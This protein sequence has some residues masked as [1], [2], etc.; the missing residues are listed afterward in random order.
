MLDGSSTASPTFAPFLLPAMLPVL[1]GLDY[2][3]RRVPQPRVLIAVVAFAPMAVLVAALDLGLEGLWWAIAVWVIVRLVLLARAM[4]KWPQILILD[5]P[6]V[7][8]DDWHRELI[9]QTLDAIAASSRTQ[10]IYVSHTAGEHPRCINQT[11][12]FI[13]CQLPQAGPDPVSIRSRSQYRLEIRE[14]PPLP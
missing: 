14:D 6:M 12:R 13:P 3:C 2:I 8:L 11:L 4:V 9:L 10:L 7:G 1:V 5:E